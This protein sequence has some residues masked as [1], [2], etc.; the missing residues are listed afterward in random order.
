MTEHKLVVDRA[1]IRRKAKERE[2]K[3]RVEQEGEPRM[4]S[5]QDML[6]ATTYNANDHVVVATDKS[7]ML[8]H[9]EDCKKV[10]SGGGVVDAVLITMHMPLPYAGTLDELN[11]CVKEDET[12]LSKFLRIDSFIE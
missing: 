9:A 7:E 2:N 12:I 4:I 1:R 11:V 8:G 10:C 5:Q 6:M 3:K